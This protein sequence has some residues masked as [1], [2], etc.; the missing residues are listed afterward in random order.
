MKVNEPLK[1]ATCAKCDEKLVWVKVGKNWAMT[2]VYKGK[3]ERD[4]AGWPILG[5]RSQHIHGEMV[6]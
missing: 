4:K 3:V 5:N 1:S 2:K 6:Q